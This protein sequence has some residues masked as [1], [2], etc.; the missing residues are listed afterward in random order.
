[1]LSLYKF[2]LSKNDL[3]WWKPE[4]F[5]QGEAQAK[6]KKKLFNIKFRQFAHE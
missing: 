2:T 3:Q 1:M 6:K 4:T 5:R